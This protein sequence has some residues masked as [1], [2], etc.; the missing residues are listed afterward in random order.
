MKTS[1]FALFLAGALA[2]PLAAAPPVPLP[3]KGHV[4]LLD[5]D[6]VLEGDVERVG[7]RFRIRRAAG[8]L[9]IPANRVAGLVDSREAAFDAVK[10]RAKLTDAND[11]LRLA[12]WC[13]SHG[14]PNQA[15][16]EADA[17]ASIDPKDLRFKMAYCEPIKR[18]AVLQPAATA[19]KE[20]A[21]PAPSTAPADAPTVDVSPESL[22][23]FITKIQPILMNTCANC[24]TGDHGG[25]FHLTRAGNKY[26][27]Q[28]NLAAVSTFLNH[29]Q[30]SA[31]ALLTKAVTV[32]GNTGLPPIKDRQTAA[33]RH[34]EAWACQ[35]AGQAAPVA[36]PA[37]LPPAA[38]ASAPALPPKDAQAKANDFASEPAAPSVPA[39]GVTQASAQQKPAPM[40]VA[41]PK[42]DPSD[43]FDP[44]I[45]NQQ[46]GAPKK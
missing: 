46:N 39:E 19:A 42:T 7:D 4:L 1:I 9:F 26:G 30:P 3:E 21:A 44:E 23:L 2:T 25:K 24:H 6:E 20:P 17:A 40:P 45:F 15:I 13:L 34:L 28:T 38:I 29:E 12:R 43:P 31:S 16:A 41:K 14:L 22:S 11:R 37:A 27:L 33:Y 10:K 8:E 36:P 18:Q 35:A 32:H 5:N